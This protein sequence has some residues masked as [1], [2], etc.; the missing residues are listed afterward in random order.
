MA[1]KKKKATAAAA[2]AG[3]AAEPQSKGAKLKIEVLFDPSY[4]IRYR[5]NFQPF[6]SKRDVKDKD[7]DL[8][9]GENS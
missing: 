6:A 7:E 9:A 2:G 8:T 3:T 5:S 4:A 1:N